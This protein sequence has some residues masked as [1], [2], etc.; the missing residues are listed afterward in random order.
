V[1]ITTRGHAAHVRWPDGTPAVFASSIEEPAS[2]AHRIDL[3]FYVPKGTTVVGGFADGVGAMLDGDGKRVFDFASDVFKSGNYFS[4]PV[5]PGQDGKLWQLASSAGRR[6]LM[7][8]PPYFARNADEL[9]LPREVVE[10]D[11]QE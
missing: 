7:T 11:A 10:A 1:D 4:I 2:L 5:E 9:M 3:Y 8:V 6:L